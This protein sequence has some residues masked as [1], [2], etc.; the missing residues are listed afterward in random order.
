MLI[1]G[2]LAMGSVVIWPLWFWPYRVRVRRL[3]IFC[4]LIAG[5]IP[6]APEIVFG[7]SRFAQTVRSWISVV[8]GY[9][10]FAFVVLRAARRVA[11]KRLHPANENRHLRANAA[12]RT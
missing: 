12:V 9:G 11:R 8:F 3:F 6:F 1:A 4:L 5:A 10:D 7:I 2:A